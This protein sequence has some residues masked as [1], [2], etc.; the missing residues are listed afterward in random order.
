MDH[1][2]G[3]IIAV[4]AYIAISSL[5]NVIVTFELDW[6]TKASLGLA[7]VILLG[8]ATA[9]AWIAIRPNSPRWNASDD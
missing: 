5:S 4:I 7:I 6:I 1:L 9:G 3:A 8:L 2:I